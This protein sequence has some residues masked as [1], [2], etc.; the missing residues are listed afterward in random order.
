MNVFVD[1]DACPCRAEIIEVCKRHGVVPVFVANKGIA[2]V[3]RE[4]NAKMEVVSGDFDAADDW[5]VERAQPGDLVLTA[6]LLLA[7]RVVK[8]SA[9]VISFKG[10]RLTDDVIHELVAHREIQKH[11]REM[12]L[13]SAQPMPY[14]KKHRGTFKS[15]LHL[16]LERN[17]P[18]AP[19]A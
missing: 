2:G 4:T 19:S 11:L 13:P 18:K 9:A 17:K 7:Q 6:D 8:N 3:W 16:W 14:N 15:A 12:G 10:D 1:A 5:M